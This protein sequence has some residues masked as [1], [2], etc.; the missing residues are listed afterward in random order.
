MKSWSV[1]SKGLLALSSKR[2]IDDILDQDRLHTSTLTG[3][4]R[5]D[6]FNQAPRLS[7]KA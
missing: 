3:F 1:N 6:L 2:S 7:D 4:A 5:V